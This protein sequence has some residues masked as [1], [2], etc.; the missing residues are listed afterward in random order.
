M[1]RIAAV[2]GP[3]LPHVPRRPLSKPVWDAVRP[4]LGAQGRRGPGAIHDQRDRFVEETSICF[5]RS[6]LAKPPASRTNVVGRAHQNQAYHGQLHQLGGDPNRVHLLHAGDDLAEIGEYFRAQE[7]HGGG[8]PGGSRSISA[9]I[10]TPPRRLRRGRR[11]R[12]GRD[13]GP[14]EMAPAPGGWSLTSP[15]R[16]Q[17]AVPWARHSNRCDASLRLAG[18]R[19]WRQPRAPAATP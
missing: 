13:P 17:P 11:E 19:P 4:G 18:G 1:A 3:S 6:H 9:E 12:R 14:S 16:E 8:A 7:S 15:S 10:A 5:E 2:T